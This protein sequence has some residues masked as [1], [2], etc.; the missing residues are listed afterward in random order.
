MFTS[1]IP[2]NLIFKETIKEETGVDRP[3]YERSGSTHKER[4][5]SPPPSDIGY[6]GFN[7]VMISDDSKLSLKKTLANNYMAL[8]YEKV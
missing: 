5:Q 4:P 6:S 3:I 1:S 7:V 2:I 8:K